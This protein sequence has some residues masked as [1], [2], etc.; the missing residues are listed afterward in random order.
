MKIIKGSIFSCER[1]RRIVK[2]EYESTDKD[3]EKKEFHSTVTKRKEKAQKRESVLWL[4]DAQ[5]VGKAQK[6]QIVAR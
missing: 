4:P 1:N 3:E 6:K 5:K 2:R